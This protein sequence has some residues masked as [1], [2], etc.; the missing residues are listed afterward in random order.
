MK[1]DSSNKQTMTVKTDQISSSQRIRD[2][3]RRSRARRKEYIQDLEQRLHKFEALGVQVTREVQAAG[4]KV[5]VENTHLRSLLRL[6]GVSD[7]DIHEYLT[8]HTASVVLQNFHSGTVL[9]T[10]SPSW[11]S[12]GPNT[13]SEGSPQP[14][15]FHWYKGLLHEMADTEPKSS[16]SNPAIHQQRIPFD[17]PTHG[18]SKLQPPSRNQGSGQ[19]TPCETAAE[20]ITSIRNYSDARGVRSEIGCQSSSNCMVRN[21]DILQLLDE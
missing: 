13:V 20:I 17:S 1:T 9:E 4:R 19:S 5:A 3:Q 16:L 6:H 15:S 12:S 8:A 7:Q 2:N 18:T 11:K 10:R 21:V 14:S